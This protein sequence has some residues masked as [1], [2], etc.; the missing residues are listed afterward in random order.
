MLIVMPWLAEIVESDAAGHRTPRPDAM[1]EWVR[2]EHGRWFLP[3]SQASCVR[4]Y[5]LAASCFPDAFDPPRI[6]MPMQDRS[7]APT[8]VLP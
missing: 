1:A 8:L 7:G 3:F 4:T 5:R 6:S 2:R